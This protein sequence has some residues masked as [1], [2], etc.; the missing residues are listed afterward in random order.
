MAYLE[1]LN[2]F[3]PL[4]FFVGK[5]I[6]NDTYRIVALFL[7]IQGDRK[8]VCNRMLVVKIVMI[9]TFFDT[10]NLISIIQKTWKYLII[11]TATTAYI[12]LDVMVGI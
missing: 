10:C 7:Y 11:F 2:E 1:P 4:L 6:S 9:D 5:E 12:C 3:F 8:I